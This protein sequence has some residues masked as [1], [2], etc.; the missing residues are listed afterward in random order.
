MSHK[1]HTNLTNREKLVILDKLDR[2]EITAGEACVKYSLHR[3]TMP[4]WRKDREK[5]EKQV[6]EEGRP[7]KKRVRVDDGL[8]CIQAGV[9][10]FYDENQ[11]QPEELKQPLT[12]KL[13][14]LCL[15]LFQ[16]FLTTLLLCASGRIIVRKAINIKNKLMAEHEGTELLS[17]LELNAFEKF[18]ASRSWAGKFARESGWRLEEVYQPISGTSAKVVLPCTHSTC[19][20]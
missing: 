2:N 11:A 7:E 4:N 9:K 1:P 8:G 6:E 13:L 19:S 14:C 20:V 12:C 18:N 16:I 15:S 5:I 10:E 17:D 3:N